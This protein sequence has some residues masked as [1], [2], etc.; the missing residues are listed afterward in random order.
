MAT[1]EV[2]IEL[3]EVGF[4][5]PVAIFQTLI[6]QVPVSTTIFHAEIVPA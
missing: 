3:A 6:V 1:P 5:V 2:L 4:A